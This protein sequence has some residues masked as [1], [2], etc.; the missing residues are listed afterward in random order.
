M[1]LSECGLSKTFG[2]S[3]KARRMLT[4]LPWRKILAGVTAPVLAFEKK[5]DQECGAVRRKSRAGT[6]TKRPEP[7]WT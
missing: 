1:P 5:F 6:Q 3:L 2:I 4:F 7:D